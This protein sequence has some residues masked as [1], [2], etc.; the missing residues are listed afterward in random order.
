[1]IVIGR[2]LYRHWAVFRKVWWT[3]MMFNFVEPF[4]YLSALGYGLGAFVRPMGG[5]SYVDYIAPGIVASSAMFAATF[6]STY[7][8]FIRLHYQKTFHAMLAGPVTVRDII[9]GEVLY[10]ILKS[11]LFG[12][13][14]LLVTV[15][16]GN[17]HSW[18]ALLIP[19]FL[20]L[21]GALFALLALCYT[22]LIKSIDHFNYYIT[23]FITPIHLFSGAFFPVEA[24]PAWVNALIWLNPL[25]HSVQISRA[26]S[27]ETLHPGLWLHVVL[28]LAAIAILLPLPVRLFKKRLIT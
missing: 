22:G 7:G 9:V 20:A 10:A 6:E 1:M 5:V 12:I 19:P 13:V 15:L 4:L 18:W 27:L 26:L 2:V 11:M 3:N 14:I 25:Y 28:M 8:S 24:M 21:P 23:L 17:V 16:F